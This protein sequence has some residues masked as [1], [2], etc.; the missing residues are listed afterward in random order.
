LQL[1]CLLEVV[2][3]TG[4]LLLRERLQ[5]GV[6]ATIRLSRAS[7]VVCTPPIVMFLRFA[8]AISCWLAAV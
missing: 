8:I 3:Q 1:L 6:A 7:P 2:A 4:Q 5:V